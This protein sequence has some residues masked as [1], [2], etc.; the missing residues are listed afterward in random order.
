[1]VSNQY[2]CGVRTRKKNVR[3]A[4]T[5]AT[6]AI[7][8]LALNRARAQFLNDGDAVCSGGTMGWKEK[9]RPGSIAPSKGKDPKAA[10]YSE[11]R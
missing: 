11:R 6:F 4:Q 9:R 7:S 2:P 10:R 8:G 1:M 3:E 5:S